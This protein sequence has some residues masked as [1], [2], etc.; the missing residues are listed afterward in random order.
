MFNRARNPTNPTSERS[1]R[2]I[3]SDARRKSNK[4]NAREIQHSI[5]IRSLGRRLL[6]AVVIS[7]GYVATVFLALTL[8]VGP[9]N[10]AESRLQILAV[11]V[12]GR[13]ACVTRTY[14]VEGQVGCHCLMPGSVVTS[15]SS[16]IEVFS[17]DDAERGWLRPVIH[18]LE[19]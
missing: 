14:E 12:G 8:L 15:V 18:A 10:A 13:I 1:L 5:V 7:T 4:S 2:A 6:T 19:R 16:A 11:A 17:V 9:A 3:S